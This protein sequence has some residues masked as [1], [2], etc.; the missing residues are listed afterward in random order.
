LIA[1]KSE[2][3]NKPPPPPIVCRVVGCIPTPFDRGLRRPRGPSCP[4]RGGGT[5]PASTAGVCTSSAAAQPRPGPF[6]WKR[7]GKNRDPVGP[8]VYRHR[9]GSPTLYNV[10]GGA[11]C[12]TVRSPSG[13]HLAAGAAAGPGAPATASRT[14]G[15]CTS[16]PSAGRGSTPRAP[17]RPGGGGSRPIAFRASVSI[18]W[19]F[20]FL[21]S[22]Y[23]TGSG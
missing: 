13:S 2:M 7:D 19:R 12:Q 5:A 11:I 4:D 6:S 18:D 10:V 20:A 22:E 9:S 3:Q 21:V 16:Q 14:R 17:S 23:L 8:T 15:G 1:S